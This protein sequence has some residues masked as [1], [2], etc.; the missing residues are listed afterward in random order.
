MQEVY[1]SQR[2]QADCQVAPWDLSDTFPW[3]CAAVLNQSK[4][5]AAVTQYNEIS[6]WWESAFV[7][8]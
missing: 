2:H 3:E 4:A 7:L 6:P 1:E 5:Y 8:G